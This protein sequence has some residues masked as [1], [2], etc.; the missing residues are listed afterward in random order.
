MGASAP[1]KTILKRSQHAAN[2][3]VIVL[4]KDPGNGRFKHIVRNAGLSGVQ[5]NTP[6]PLVANLYCVSRLYGR[7]IHIGIKDMYMANTAII[8]RGVSKY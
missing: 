6:P 8:R 2:S 7:S 5:H 4:H 3:V 1:G